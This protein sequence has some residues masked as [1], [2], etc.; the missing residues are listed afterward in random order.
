M[1]FYHVEF[2]SFGIF[3]ANVLLSKI[4]RAR[5]YHHMIFSPT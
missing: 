5:C 1:G 3:T 4:S 2:G